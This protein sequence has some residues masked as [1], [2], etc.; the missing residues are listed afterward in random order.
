MSL[1]IAKLNDHVRAA[2]GYIALRMFREAASELAG[3]PPELKIGKEVLALSLTIYEELEKWDL[4]QTVALTLALGTQEP[5][6]AL[7]WARATKRL[8]N[9]E[10]ARAILIDLLT[11]PGHCEFLDH[12]LY[13]ELARCECELGHLAAAE[14]ALEC[15]F[16][17]DPLTDWM[18]RALDDK[19]L[20]PLWDSMIEPLRIDP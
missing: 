19:A 3:L 14:E 17:L 1:Q 12:S 10:L 9:T 18:Q 5:R 13:Y 11:K 4:A 15:A 20:A 8:G 16:R 7:S 2:E 6:F